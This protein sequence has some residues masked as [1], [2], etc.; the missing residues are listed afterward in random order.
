MG[1][2]REQKL[3]RILSGDDRS[4]AAGLLRG[5]LRVAEPF[6]AAGM[7]LRNALYDAGILKVHQL[8]RPTVSV[9][10]ITTGGTGK[11]PVVHWVARRM[12]QHRLR[13]AVLTRGY[14]ASA[15]GSDEQLVLASA[16]GNRG[17][18]IANPDRVAAAIKS[19]RELPQ[20][21]VF[22]LDDGF[23]H[24]RAGRDCNLVLISATQPFG[25]DH[26]LPR[27]LLREPRDGLR[28]A[29][30]FLITRSDQ[31]DE[32]RLRQIESSLGNRAP[33]YHAS[34]QLAGLRDAGGK[35]LPMEELSRRRFALFC[36]IGDPVSL[37]N[38]LRAFGE[39]FVDSRIFPDHHDYTANDLASIDRSK[40]DLLVTTEKDWVKLNA[41]T[42]S[43]FPIYRIELELA[44]HDGDE[45]KLLAQIMERVE[46]R[47]QRRGAAVSK[48]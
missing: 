33:I 8:P 13:P 38:Q 42:R 12:I 24:R 30:A 4:L 34:H 25:F 5:A 19:L 22:I 15:A 43:S 28:R 21:D 32:T 41:A 6:Y 39:N 27:G 46:S 16:L 45:G 31:V 20:P 2:S 36:G 47:A 18:V 48:E 44:F 40:I 17:Y 26:V 35:S 9:G 7:R 10:N 23:Q 11:T 3:I 1:D 14:R 37:Q 29:D